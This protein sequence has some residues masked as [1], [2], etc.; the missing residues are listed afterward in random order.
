MELL[1][2]S[3][4]YLLLALGMCLA[5][6]YSP[7]R[8]LKFTL[9]LASGFLVR[10]AF[11]ST[12]ELLNTW[13]EQ[14]HAVVAKHLAENPMLPTL[15]PHHVFDYD[16]TE[17]DVNQVWLHKPPFFL[18]IIAASVKLFGFNVFAVRLPSYLLSGLIPVLI[19]QIAEKLNFDKAAN[20]AAA[21]WIFN[22][23]SVYLAIG[24]YPTDHNDL[25]FVALITLSWWAFLRYRERRN[26]ARLIVLSLTVSAAILTKW[27]TGLWIFLPWGLTI[28]KNR[29]YAELKPLFLAALLA[30]LPVVLW[31][32]YLLLKFPMEAKYELNYNSLHFWVPVEGHGGP[33]W[34]HFNELF[35]HY[36]YLIPVL[37][38]IG[39]TVAYR[40]HWEYVAGVVFVFLFFS[41]AAT[42]MSAFTFMLAAPMLISS[43]VVIEK[44]VR[45]KPWL[46]VFSVIAILWSFAPWHIASTIS[47]ENGYRTSRFETTKSLIEW[48]SHD[49]RA[50]WVIFNV[51]RHMIPLVLFYSDALPYERSVEEF[52]DMENYQ[53]GVWKDN[54]IVE[55]QSD[56]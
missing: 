24:R 45:W 54:Q 20:W 17:W 52:P 23:F 31:Y 29:K 39:F 51:P 47:L 32:G 6:F 8:E 41:V 3:W 44:L 15:Y 18:W 5:S 49:S 19:Y 28:F 34:Y 26:T 56:N 30:L 27:L 22:P 37:T 1:L 50:D 40:K 55:W 35:W 25:F 36:G 16:Y 11:G 48:T 42:K 43:A 38:V 9:F 4:I 46:A 2:S 53:I 14:Y 13:D 12:V 7:R 10:F 33:W 21:L